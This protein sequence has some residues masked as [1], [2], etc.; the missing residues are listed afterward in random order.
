MS[1]ET[2]ETKLSVHEIKQDL[3]FLP[4]SALSG[5]AGVEVQLP[6]VLTDKWQQLSLSEWLHALDGDKVLVHE[7]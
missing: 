1:W 5:R 4:R 6:V 2:K 7:K 3:G